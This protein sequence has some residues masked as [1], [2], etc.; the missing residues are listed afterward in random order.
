MS[1]T[2]YL[3]AMLS[4]VAYQLQIHRFFVRSVTIN[5][6]LTIIFQWKNAHWETILNEVAL[7]SLTEQSSLLQRHAEHAKFNRNEYGTY[8][9]IFKNLSLKSSKLGEIKH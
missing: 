2:P 8:C 9:D 6:I 4:P 7:E 1:V 3:M 5:A